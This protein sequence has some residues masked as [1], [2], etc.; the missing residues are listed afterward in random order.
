M[1]SAQEDVAAVPTQD[2]RIGG[3][4]KQRYFLIGP[5]EGRTVPPQGSGLL[6][7][8]PGGNGGEDFLPFVKRVYKHAT[9]KG[10]VVAQ[11]VAPKW[12][13]RQEV[14][15]P[16]AKLKTAGAAFTTEQFVDAVIDDV[17]ARHKLNP[18]RIATLS[19]SS[20]GPAAY[21]VSLS[22]PK[23]RGSFVAMS[24]YKPAQLPPLAQAKGHAYYLFHSPQDRVCPMR[25]AEQAAETLIKNGATVELV[26]YEG[27]HG[28]QGNVF[29]QIRQGLEWLE[30][31][32]NLPTD[33]K[34]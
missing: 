2:V 26:K 16:T 4:E 5:H 10:Y 13:E 17:T 14:V 18:E 24:V 21:A 12:N 22:N 34:K 31:N 6:L 32:S 1:I 3:D 28:W 20:G 23:V 15:W 25:M 27:G 29:G 33:P 8:M 19:W 7:V 11:L 30:K 9:P